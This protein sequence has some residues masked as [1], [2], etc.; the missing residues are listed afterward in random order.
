MAEVPSWWQAN[1]A[2]ELFGREEEHKDKM[3]KS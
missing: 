1:R 2:V 3:T